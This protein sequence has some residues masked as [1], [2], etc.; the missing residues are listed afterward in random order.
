MIQVR[1]NILAIN[2]KIATREV[3]H[4]PFK[5]V[6]VSVHGSTIPQNLPDWVW[7][8]ESNQPES[9]HIVYNDKVAP[10]EGLPVWVQE[11]PNPPHQLEIIKTYGSAANPGST[12][13]IFNLPNH[14]ANHQIPTEISA[15]H[16]PVLT[17][18]PA[19]Q[20][21]KTTGSGLNLTVYTQPY[22]YHSGGVRYTFSG[23]FSDMTPY[24]P[25]AGMIRRVLVYLDLATGTLG[26]V[27]G[28]EVADT[29]PAPWPNIPTGTRPSAYIT[30]TASQTTISTAEHIADTRDIWGDGGDTITPDHIGQIMY[31]VD[32][33]EFTPELPMVNADGIMLTV[34]G[35]IMVV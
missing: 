26:Y 24:L 13:S 20:S 27:A 29:D 7:V 35:Y 33:L 1:D 34:D 10:I 23:L 14:A 12:I 6:I 31:S 16:D 28:T 5:A 11:S 30:L 9:R 4:E 17:Y 25:S 19:I 2:E 3:R 22:I 8:A 32:G 18:L 21:L 15:G